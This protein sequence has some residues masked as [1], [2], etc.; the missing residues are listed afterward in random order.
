MTPGRVDEET[1]AALRAAVMVLARRLR[2]QL[3]GD[4]LAGG[5]DLSAT[6]LAVLGRV[7]RCGPMTPGQLARAEHVRPPSMTKVIESLEGRG[8]LRRE[9]HPTDGRQYLVSRTEA[10]EA[11]VEAS[12]KLRTAWLA[13]HVGK[14]SD[15]DQQAIAAATAA[16]GRLAELP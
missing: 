13:D 12:R 1:V 7:G 14:L 9:P 15:S 16:L 6:E 8:L 2:Y 5:D 11:F 3:A 10:A 4:Q